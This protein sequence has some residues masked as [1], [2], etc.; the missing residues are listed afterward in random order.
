MLHKEAEEAISR[1]KETVFHQIKS[2]LF[3]N[4]ILN[5][6]VSCHYFSFISISFANVYFHKEYNASINKQQ[7]CLHYP[8][9]SF[10]NHLCN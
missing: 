5:L 10:S 6:C 3:M 1:F 7:V 2:K 4:S 8:V 9:R